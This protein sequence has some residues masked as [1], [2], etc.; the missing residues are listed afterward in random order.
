MN[1]D[2]LLS[3]LAARNPLSTPMQHSAAR[4]KFMKGVAAGVAAA[5]LPTAA[6]AQS[7]PLSLLTWDAYADPNLLDL[8]RS[9]TD[10]DGRYEI[11][12]S[13]PTSVNRLR[14]GET[15]VWDFI[16]VNNPWARNVMHPA[17]LIRPLPRD[18]FDPLRGWFTALYEVLLGA[19]QGPRFGGF[20]A[21][22]GVDETIALIDRA[23]AGEL[24]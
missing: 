24:V 7:R 4:R 10:V 16:N 20:I 18:R 21:L 22:Y 3:T 15:D 11:H 23:L 2:R 5:S 19:S 8:W 14:A 13:D 17:G 9:T 12:I 1:K 6:A